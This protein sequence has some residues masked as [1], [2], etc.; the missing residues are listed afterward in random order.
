MIVVATDD[1]RLYH[2][3]VTALRERGVT[4][5]TIEPDDDLPDQAS[6][7]ITGVDDTRA[8]A[9]P[10]ADP[11]PGAAAEIEHVT[12]DPDDIRPAIESA[13][14]ILRGGD[15][16]RIIGVDPGTRPGVAILEGQR[17]ISAFQL[18]VAEAVETIQQECDSATNPL[19][20]VG[21]GA[22][23]QSAQIINEL[24]DVDI[25]LV[26][27][28]GTTPYL[29]SGARGMGDVIAAINIARLSGEP[30]ER[31]EIEPTPGEL[32]RIKNESR[33][34]SNG[35]RT[36]PRRLARRVATGELTVQE[37][38]TIHRTTADDVV[39]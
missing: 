6:V 5:T 8:A 21:D 32:Q 18:P 25:E 35:D 14:S 31:R 19:V 2:E 26:D 3:A 34:Q 30:I 37:A 13:L 39:D 12:A 36:I 27:E 28:T 11:A 38:L 1:F 33:A 10:E 20:R 24:S 22:R 29:G 9:D 7:V 4:F 17:V 23:L 15:D 16:R